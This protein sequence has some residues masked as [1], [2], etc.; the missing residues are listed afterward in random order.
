MEGQTQQTHAVM[1]QLEDALKDIAGKSETLE[2]RLGPAMAA[3]IQSAE[4]SDLGLLNIT[5]SKC[6]ISIN[7]L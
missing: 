1:A 2:T 3:L 4:V 7:I 5:M 6:A